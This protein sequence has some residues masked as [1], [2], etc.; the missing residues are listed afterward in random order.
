MM[1]Q[2]EIILLFISRLVLL[3]IGLWRRS[4]SMLDNKVIY[5]EVFKCRLCSAKFHNPE[6]L[7]IHRMVDHKGHYLTLTIKR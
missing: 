5:G 3:T 1:I 2:A 6:E 7:R 4:I